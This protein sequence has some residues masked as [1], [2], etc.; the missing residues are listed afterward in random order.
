[1][2]TCALRSA[3]LP[4]PRIAGTWPPCMT[5]PSDQPDPRAITID[6]TDDYALMLAIARGSE[7]ALSSL[8]D[9]HGP[10]V[11]ACARR[12]LSDSSEAE[13]VLIDVF[14]E[15]WRRADQYD[16]E[17][18]TPLTYLMTLTRSRAIDRRRAAQSRAKVAT[19][20]SADAPDRPDASAATPLQ[21]T[22]GS[23][24]AAIIRNALGRLDPD[25]RAALE[26]SYY[27]G[28]THTEIAARLGRPLGTVKGWIR[29]GL[30]RLR[31]T[32]RRSYDEPQPTR[33]G[34]QPR[35]DTAPPL[36]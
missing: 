10:T 31:D 18:A 12:I 15:V 28:L 11:N 30:L 14:Y 33:D 3:I 16:P 8:F 4:W 19:L 36:M 22:L 32:L 6:A 27:E 13:D 26:C 20:Q 34:N 17:R 35:Q 29:Q 25:Q 23:E 1:M 2:M 21:N 7:P 9:R 5:L 24:R